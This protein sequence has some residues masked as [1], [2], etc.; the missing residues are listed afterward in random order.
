MDFCG[1]GELFFYLNNGGL[2]E[3]TTKFYVA[4]VVESIGQLHSKDIIYRDL[5]PEN[6]MVSNDGY[7]KLIDFGFCKLN[8]RNDVYTHSICGTPEY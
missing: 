4:Q 1:G 2:D 7:I 6:V 3:S 8:M 5:K